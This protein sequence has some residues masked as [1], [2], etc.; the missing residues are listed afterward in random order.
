MQTIPHTTVPDIP[1]WKFQ[2]PICGDLLTCEID[3]WEQAD[4]GSW[5]VGETGL[6]LSCASEPDIDDDSFDDW[7]DGHFS[8][9]Y[10]DWLPLTEKVRRWMVKNY[11]FDMEA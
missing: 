10:V 2:C 5:Q 9:P 11:R 4:D 7:L 8:M 1:G 3:E 6:H